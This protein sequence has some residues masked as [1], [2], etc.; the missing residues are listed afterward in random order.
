MFL[1][2]RFDYVNDWLQPENYD[3]S[4][5]HVWAMLSTQMPLTGQVYQKP[6]WDNMVILS[7][8]LLL[9][10]CPKEMH[11]IYYRCKSKF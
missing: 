7:M 3:I 5:K 6:L 11:A 8:V 10:D 2:V 1:N 4:V 9:T